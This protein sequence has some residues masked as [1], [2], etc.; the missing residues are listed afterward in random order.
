MLVLKNQAISHPPRLGAGDAEEVRVS[1]DT[2]AFIGMG[3]GGVE[4]VH[5]E[6]SALS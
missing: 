3:G 5:L 2:D 6:N 4:V 1:S